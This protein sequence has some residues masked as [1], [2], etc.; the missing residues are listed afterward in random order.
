[1]FTCVLLGATL[2]L[3]DLKSDI[4]VVSDDFFCL[5]FNELRSDDLELN[6]PEQLSTQVS[7]IDVIIL[8]LKFR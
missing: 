6:C 3:A 4:D 5:L 8:N 1:M 2:R 7:M